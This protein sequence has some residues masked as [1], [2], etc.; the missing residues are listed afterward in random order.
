[1]TRE[2]YFAL[3]STASLDEIAKMYIELCSKAANRAAA[4]SSFELASSESSIKVM[5]K[6]Q[7]EDYSTALDRSVNV[8]K[9]F[10]G[11]TVASFI[12]MLILS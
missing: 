10:L 11:I 9:I 8:T 3:G 2:G 5:G 7:F 4:V 6:K 1:R 12:T